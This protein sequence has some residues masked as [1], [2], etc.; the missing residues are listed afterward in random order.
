MDQV[1]ALKQSCNGYLGQLG[2]RYK[3]LEQLM[4]DRMN[5]D[6]VKTK[7]CQLI[8]LF[9]SYEGKFGEYVS[10]LSGKAESD[11]NVVFNS[12]KLNFTEFETRVK[13][14]MSDT[15]T[16]AFKSIT[17][18]QDDEC[19]VKSSICSST[20][21]SSERLREARL[22]KRLAEQ[23]M[24]QMKEQQ[25]LER[26]KRDLDERLATLQM[27]NE[28]KNAELEVEILEELECDQELNEPAQNNDEPLGNVETKHTIN[29]VDSACNDD[30]INDAPGVG[31]G[32]V[33]VNANL[34]SNT[35]VD[36]SM[37][38]TVDMVNPMVDLCNMMLLSM[39]M[40]K[41][42]LAKFDGDPVKYSG[43]INSFDVNVACK[44]KD[45]KTKLMYLLQYCEG[46]ARECIECCDLMPSDEGY[47]K[48]RS[49]LASQYGQ[50]HVISQARLAKVLNR[51]PI[52]PND[53][54][55]LRELAREMSSC[56]ITLEQMGHT[57][58]MNATDNLLKIQGILPTQL[59]ARWAE[60]ANGLFLAGIE[61]NF[62][63]LTEFIERQAMVA[64]NLFG[65]NIGQGHK[66]ATGKAHDKQG[67]GGKKWTT[68]STFGN[69]EEGKV[70]KRKCPCCSKIHDLETCDVF[71]GKTQKERFKLVRQ[72]RLC[73]NCL[74]PSHVAKDC[75]RK[76]LCNQRDCRGKHH[77]LLHFPRPDASTGA[78]DDRN[79]K[80]GIVSNQ[81]SATSLAASVNKK[82][83][84]RIIPVKVRN[85]GREIETWALLDGGSDVSLC[86]KR[87]AQKLGIKGDK[88]RF[89][90]S[91]I[92]QE[93]KEM[94]GTEIQLSVSGI[95]E[96][97]HIDLEGVWTVEKLPIS[98]DSIPR[99]TDT[100]RWSHLRDIT[101][102]QIDSNEVML[103]IGGDT[104]EA[105]WVKEDRQGKKGEPYAMRTVLGW[106][107]LGPTSRQNKQR[108]GFTSNFTHT[109]MG[110]EL[111]QRQVEKFWK[112]DF[113][114]H[115][116][117]GER[118]LSVEDQ[119]AEVIF[120]KT[121][122]KVDGH[123]EIGL[124]WR[125]PD[126]NLP[127]GKKMAETR[128][129]SLQRRL[130]KDQVMHK[131][132]TETVEGYIEKG[133][134]QGVPDV[135]STRHSGKTWYLPHHPVVHPQKGKVR[136]VFDC[137]ARS[138]GTSLNDQLLQG[139]DYNNN[140]VGVLTRFREERVALM[141]DIEA[142]FHQVKVASVDSDALRFLW[143][144]NGDL[145]KTPRTYKMLVHL[146]GATSS[147]S[148]AAFALR[149]AAEE[150]GGVGLEEATKA[151]KDNFYVDDCLVSVA[152]RQDA[153]DLSK[154]LRKV[155]SA[156]GF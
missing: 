40:P 139:P 101:I 53:G 41:A 58:N 86:D 73:D 46:K 146:F 80:V 5:R 70:S 17:I 98:A 6:Q 39:N 75:R 155:L 132:Y 85:H 126:V 12:Q 7:Y 151:V 76:P 20:S 15:D 147:P 29:V 23:R 16:T 56:R 26:A 87:L 156:G 36:K 106:T 84:L 93:N 99:P 135:D 128:L 65:K 138:H 74:K 114:E 88:K 62:A 119:R 112:L 22:K 31:M 103:L 79:D 52:K 54:N 152:T 142:M 24:E 116:Q 10:L 143:W 59:Q 2:R 89:N 78:G 94:S 1:A 115:H 19:S 42:E 68:L 125:H 61:P 33:G 67:S 9:S 69:E 121:V 129:R 144:P 134:A 113:G 100:E 140:L 104:P 91:T 50:P 43:F 44:V 48:A 81:P 105:F 27:E 66:A 133:Y 90:L 77:A 55:S 13:A 57:A 136:V 83:C 145:S 37:R 18:P 130:A 45:D 118:G 137:A 30:V 131:K 8:D 110:D 97:E 95:Q 51:S 4:L 148:C 153:I 14:W 60:R 107:L 11:A 108:S 109:C 64:N 72:S 154:G 120:K 3:E 124:P 63:H 28:I 34:N 102:P 49:I 150:N 149:K 21:M 127:D 141:A 92:N 35:E 111:L 71:K 82:V 25:R 47:K 122:K 38:G 96:T 117:E 123:Y 32:R